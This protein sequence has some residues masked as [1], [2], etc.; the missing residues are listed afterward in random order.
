[1]GQRVINFKIGK[2]GSLRV[3]NSRNPDP[4]RILDELAQLSQ[5][6]NGNPDGF[7]V[8]QHTHDHEHNHDHNHDEAQAHG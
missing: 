7:K 8:E 4:Q 5:A 1:M 6:A 2:D 3:D